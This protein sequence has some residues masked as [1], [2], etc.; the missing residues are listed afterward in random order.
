MSVLVFMARYF[1][2]GIS[3]VVPCVA[4]CQSGVVSEGRMRRDRQAGRQA[5]RLSGRQHTRLERG[6]VLSVVGRDW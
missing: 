1:Q 3:R 2:M 6:K 5:G 4:L